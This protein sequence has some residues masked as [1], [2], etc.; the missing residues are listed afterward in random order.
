VPAKG[1]KHYVLDLPKEFEGKPFEELP[2]LLRVN[3]SGAHPQFER[4]G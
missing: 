1:E 2:N 3:A 4:K